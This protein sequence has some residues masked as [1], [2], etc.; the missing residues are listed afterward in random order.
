MSD[1]SL[2]HIQ[3]IILQSKEQEKQSLH[4]AKCSHE[5]NKSRE[6]QRQELCP[7]AS[8]SR[9]SF[10]HLSNTSINESVNGN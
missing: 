10:N 6:S 8:K 5:G 4:G 9:V 2:E 7:V 1:S 3:P